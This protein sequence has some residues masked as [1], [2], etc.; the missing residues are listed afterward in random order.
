MLHLVSAP[1]FAH[2]GDSLAPTPSAAPPAPKAPV[3]AADAHLTVW[4]FVLMG[5]GA[6]T[7]GTGIWLVHRD[8]TDAA[9]PACMTAPGGRAAC[10]YGTATAWQ[11]WAF[12][13][14]GTQ[15]AIAGV[16][17]RIYEVRHAPA[18]VSLA[19]GLGELRLL[20]TF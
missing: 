13:A 14:L 17:W 6:L 16:A 18:R 12:V 2:E 3:G 10:P 9:A 5:A 11:G 4:P 15:L 1:A 8:H 19:L 20:G 7:L